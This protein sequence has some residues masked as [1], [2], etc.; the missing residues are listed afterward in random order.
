MS[1]TLLESER[2]KFNSVS[3][4]KYVAL[5]SLFGSLILTQTVSVPVY[6]AYLLVSLCTLPFVYWWLQRYEMVRSDYITITMLAIISL[7]FIASFVL[8][9]SLSFIVRGSGYIYSAFVFM[10]V[11]PRV[12]SWR[13]FCYVVSRWS[14]LLIIVG[15]P[16][17]VTSWYTFLV[18]SPPLWYKPTPLP[19][20]GL[21]IYPLSSIL[22]VSTSLG[23]VCV[24][25]AITGLSEAI[26]ERSDFAAFLTLV[27]IFGAYLTISRTAMM[28]IALAFGFLIV[29]VLLGQRSIG[30]I[31]IAGYAG[32]CFLILVAANVIPDLSLIPSVNLTGRNILWEAAYRS[33]LE[34]PFFGWGPVDTSNVIGRYV[35]DYHKGLGPHN[36]YLQVSLLSGLIGGITYAVFCVY[37]SWK[38]Y[39]GSVS[40]GNVLIF[41]LVFATMVNQ[42]FNGQSLFGLSLRSALYALAFG[43]GIHSLEKPVTEYIPM[44]K[45]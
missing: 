29:F 25:G 17:T 3:Q 32:L 13:D 24:F 20:I 31:A 6:P 10:V 18:S 5:F 1:S 34:R 37:A 26:E 15:L 40:I 30:A 11:I 9:P 39:L 14:A 23:A 41:S 16:F 19:I 33:I 45:R 35:H 42:L 4:Y 27:C 43:F 7:C 21:K 44:F 12:V 2:W 28:S 36:S 38:A 22:Q 8:N